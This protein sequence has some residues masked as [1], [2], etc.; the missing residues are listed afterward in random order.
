MHLDR[1]RRAHAL[2]R[3]A[4]VEPDDPRH[5]AQPGLH[6]TGVCAAHAVPRAHAPALGD[7][8][9]RPPARHGG[10]AAGRRLAP[11]RAGARRGEPGALRRGAGQAGDQPL[12]RAPEQHGAP[13]PAAR[14]GELRVLRPRLHGAGDRRAAT[15]TT[16]AAAR[17]TAPPR[18]APRAAPRATSRPASSTSWC[19][20]TC[21]RC[22]ASRS[23]SPRRSR[24]PT[25]GHGCRRSCS[26]AARR[27][28]AARRTCASSSSGS[29][30]PTSGRS[31][32]STSTSGAGATWSSACGRWPGRRSSCA[33]TRRAGSSSPAWRPR[34][35][36]SAARVQRGLAEATFEQ[37]RQLVLLLIDRVV[38]TDA[39]VEIRYV[40]PTSP[41]SEHVRFCHLRKDYFHD[42]VQRVLDPP[43]PAGS[44]APGWRGRR[45]QLIS[46]RRHSTLTWWRS[47]VS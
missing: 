22:C 11:R 46:K 18:T 7:A 28:A 13:V 35:R 21:A 29:P 9:D 34:S 20:R 14:P 17:G 2:G 3:A 5:P 47:T 15:S 6:G 42:P 36:R 32:R 39:D 23:R 33:A 31:S 25:A 37:R 38:V 4:V 30:T 10:A 26:P 1:A 41:E 40:L 19:G 45:P 8:P 43:V 27:C 12:L 24:A 16:C 44:P